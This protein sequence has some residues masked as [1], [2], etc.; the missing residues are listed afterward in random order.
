M[1]GIAPCSAINSRQYEDTF[2]G[3]AKSL[4]SMMSQTNKNFI[5]AI[6]FYNLI[7]NQISR[8]QYDVEKL[9]KDLEDIFSATV[10]KIVFDENTVDLKKETISSLLHKAGFKSCLPT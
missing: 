5:T 4:E 7:G 10:N 9:K 2:L 1:L 3:Q 8:P 6:A